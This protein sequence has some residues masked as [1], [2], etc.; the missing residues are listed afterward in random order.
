MFAGH[1]PHV[2]GHGPHEAKLMDCTFSVFADKFELII[3]PDVDGPVH[4]GSI[5]TEVAGVR[6]T[7]RNAEGRR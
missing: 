1:A 7:Q 4:I 6:V 5:H 2:A 3:I